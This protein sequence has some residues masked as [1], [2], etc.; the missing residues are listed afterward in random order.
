[1]N[2]ILRQKFIENYNMEMVA[3]E[4]MNLIEEI[5]MTGEVLENFINE[6]FGEDF[7]EFFT[8]LDD[9]THM[10]IK[11]AEEFQDAVKNKIKAESDQ[12]F[13]RTKENLVQDTQTKQN[14]DKYLESNNL[15]VKDVSKDLSNSENIKS[16]DGTEEYQN[17]LKFIE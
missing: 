6:K 10:L 14:A 12:N 17:Q 3:V 8:T 15:D 5:D 2:N 11:S 7:E 9:G 1:M 16:G 13:E 4:L